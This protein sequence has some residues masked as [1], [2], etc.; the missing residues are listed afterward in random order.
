MLLRSSRSVIFNEL[1][2]FVTV[3]FD[4]AGRA[5]AQTDYAPIL[6][7]GTQEPVKTILS[8]YGSEIADGDVVIHN[9]VY[10]G[11]NQ[12]ADVGIYVPIF[13]EGELVAWSV[14]KG[15][16]ADIGGSTAGGYNPANTEVWQ[17][18]LRIPPVKLYEAGV[19][20]RD[21]WDFVAANI[22]FDVVMEDF[23]SM[24]GACQV[25]KR[26]VV[27]VFDRYG[28]DVVREHMQYVL[29]GSERQVRAEIKK[30]PDG[31]YRGESW[32][33]SDGVDPS[34]RYRIACE[35]RIDEDEITF[36]FSETDD[37]APGFTNMPPSAA[38]GAVRMGFS[39]ILASGGMEIPTNDGLFAPVRTVL[40]EGSLLNP[41]FPAATVLGNQMGE[42]V[43]ESIMLALGDVIPDE[44]SAPWSPSLPLAVVGVDPRTGESFVVFTLFHRGGAGAM[45][46]ADGWTFIGT[47]SST[48]IRSPDPEMFEI[49]TPHFLEYNELQVDSGGA[50]EWRGGLGTR[51]AWVSQGEKEFCVAM[52]HG[53][54]PENPPLPV[55]LR[56]GHAGGVNAYTIEFPDGSVQQLGSK[57]LVALPPGTRIVA[58]SGGGGGYGDPKLRPAELVCAEVRDGLISI[59]A[60][61]E[62]Y[63]VALD[64][65]SWTVKE[66]ETAALRQPTA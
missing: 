52:G 17:E 47:P 24:I 66:E 61:R 32:M 60:A 4:H 22:R 64:T 45:H 53:A 20:R 56:G 46:G 63:G 3:I 57:Q 18:S 43:F 16:V 41:R 65:T 40:R 15:H 49:T 12:N 36:D 62:Q 8:Y 42:Q 37:Q 44:V 29:E 26:R 25:G 38:M 27:E 21:V 14:A 2:D 50:G 23:K 35:V 33:V 54:E 58:S 7:F 19:L 11:G 1:G 13:F 9:D 30:W 39:M 10:S 59:K 28:L 48:Q 6:A 31:V 5:L 51:S 55:G 34:R